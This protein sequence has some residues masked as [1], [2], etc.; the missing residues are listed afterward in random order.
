MNRALKGVW[1]ALGA[2][3]GM[4][5][6][7]RLIRR[8][9]PAPLPAPMSWL[10]MRPLT[11]QLADVPGLLATLALERGMHVL[12][13]GAGLVPMTGAIADALGAEGRLMAT[14]PSPEML[15]RL[16][17]QV[18]ELTN[19]TTLAADPRSLPCPDGSFERVL[20]GPGLGGV[21]EPAQ[22]IREAFRILKPH[23]RLVV[24]EDALDLD[25]L[26]E[27]TVTDL[28][29]GAGFVMCGRRGG[30]WRYVLCFERP[31][32]PPYL[33]APHEEHRIE[34]YG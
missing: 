1:W 28:A 18:G 4:Q 7:A 2:Y 21:A 11:L 16:A 26:S 31:A 34:T 22:V 29:L 24:A 14:D 8:R 19:L 27:R 15:E 5:L 32:A 9:W 20:M 3:A 6:A 13:M 12:A 25:F 33:H 17:R 30:A 23:G 10:S